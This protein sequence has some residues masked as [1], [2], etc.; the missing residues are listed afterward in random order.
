MKVKYLFLLLT[1][2]F[3]YSC[4]NVPKEVLYGDTNI[5]PK[6]LSIKSNEGYFIINE[7]TRVSVSSEE[8]LKIVSNFF[9]QFEETSGW[10]PDVNFEN[11]GPI[12]FLKNDRLPIDAYKLRVDAEGIIIAASGYGGYIYAL[13]SLKQL[14][15]PSFYKNRLQNDVAWAVPFV[16][17]EDAPAFEWR[18]YMLDVSRHFFSVDQVKEVLNMMVG[19]KMNRFHWHLTDDQGWR[20]EI[21]NYPKLTEVGAWRMDYKNTNESKSD[22]WGR[23]AQKPGEKPTYG[24]F[25]SQEE[26]REI[27]AYAKELN[28]EVVPEIEMPGHAQAAMVA[29]PELACVNANPYV[30]TGGVAGNNTF[31]PGKEE[32]FVF[33]EKVLAEVIDLFPFEYVHIGGDECNKSQWKVDPYAQQRIKDEGLKDEY[34]LQSYFIKRV[35]KILNER[36]RILIG[37]DEILEGGL[38]P[39]ATVMSWRGEEGGIASAKAG[40][41]VIMTPSKYC[42]LD[43]KQGHDDMEPNLGYSYSFLSDAYNYKV[44]PE[45]L[46]DEEGKFIKGIQGNMWSESISDWSKFN[47]MNYPRVLAVAESAWTPESNKDWKDFTHR[48]HSY[49]EILDARE[50]R[51]AESA[52]SPWIEHKGD[53]EQIEISFRTEVDDLDIYYTLDGS[54]P[55]IGEIGY[56]GPFVISKSATVSAQSFRDSMAV[57]YTARL[58]FPIHKAK[59]ITSAT[60]GQEKLT[61]LNYAKL[62]ISDKSW[63]KFTNEAVIDLSFEESTEIRSVSFNSLRYTITGVYPPHTIEVLGSKDGITYT[64]LGSI[65]QMEIG[66]EQGRNKI[67]S[68]MDFDP[69]RIK[70]LRII[71]ESFKTIPEG[72]HTAG[73]AASMRIDEIVVE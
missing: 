11:G 41:E 3:I 7:Q 54:D 72:H 4:T 20:I 55:D 26:I 47:Y 23:P 29:Y 67:L 48:L 33:V 5:I 31:N 10:R 62:H 69:I 46:S 66:S 73:R 9:N 61:D 40:H 45:S 13:Q 50:T 43:L 56:N 35:E 57:G 18:G 16:E 53:G 25:Y 59:G 65:E 22:W 34:E 58:P 52:F 68:K 39:N 30:A 14:L 28:I 38:A 15:H 44:I 24:G 1:I 12:Q 6:P 36:N 17:I 42:Y 60:K 32:T 21:K 19:L 37:W 8:Q 63:L 51:Y 64:D 70:K 2:Y 27:V 71:C 49:F